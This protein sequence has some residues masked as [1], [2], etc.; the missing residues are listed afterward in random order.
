MAGGGVGARPPAVADNRACTVVERVYTSHACWAHVIHGN[1][2][3]MGLFCVRCSGPC[4]VLRSHQVTIYLEHL[5]MGININF[6]N[7]IR[8]RVNDSR[9]SYPDNEANDNRHISLDIKAKAL[10]CS[11]IHHEPQYQKTTFCTVSTSVINQ[12]LNRNL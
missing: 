6:K 2:V 1:Y 12:I 7:C 10:H 4:S 8:K 11:W 3:K 5:N 9:I